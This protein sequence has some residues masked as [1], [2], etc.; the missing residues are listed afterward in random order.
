[1]SN[2][3]NKLGG[4]NQG[5]RIFGDLWEDNNHRS[6]AGR[7]YN[8]IGLSPMLGSSNFQK[9]KYILILEI[10]DDKNDGT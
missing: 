7:V 9:I 10:G 3:I 2:R 5:I 8:P 1:M 6:E 4:G